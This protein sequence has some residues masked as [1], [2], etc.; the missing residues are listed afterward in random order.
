MLRRAWKPVAATVV[1]GAPAYFYYRS[2]HSGPQTFEFPIR[3]RGASG[4]SEMVNRTFSLV[5]LKELEAR[6]RQHAVSEAQDR[7]DGISWRH[8]TAALASNDPIEDANAHQIIER[9]ASDPSA[10]GDYLFF[11]VMD[12]H[13]GY[14]TS[15][16]LS[17]ILIKGVALELSALLADP[18]SAPQNGMLQRIKSLLW[19]TSSVTATPDADPARVSLAIQDA[20][21][22]LDKELIEA[23]LRI[24]ANNLEKAAWKSKTIPDLSQHPLALTAMLPAISGSCALMAV[25]DTAHRDLYVAC[26]GDSRAVA[27]V[28]EPSTDGKGHWRIEVLSEDQ[29]G[30]NPSELARVRSEHPREEEDYVIREGRILGGLEPS[31][32]FG[33]ARYKWPRPV[34]EALNEAFMVGNNRP[35]RAPPSLFKTPP[36]VI[37]RPVVTHRKMSLAANGSKPAQNAR[38]FLVLATD[39][40][41][42]QLSNDEVVSL[43]GGH[44]AGLKGTIPKSELPTLVPT[45]SG[46]Q[47]VE[48]KNKKAK[49]QEGSWAFNDDNLSAHLI[50]NAFG[51]GDVLALRKLL[52]IPA[53]HSRRY[54]DDVTVTVVCWEDGKEEQAK[55]VTEKLKSKL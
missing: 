43:V 41:W 16:L 14:E 39:G 11:A 7:P 42:D 13:G 18:K 1:I 32:A 33:D 23:P 26:T 36:Y 40:L 31:R 52:S 5:P 47:G 34:Q 45:S 17:R 19:S 2:Y 44:L 53:P 9:D 8:T 25:F 38:R 50:R 4:K 29:T 49:A 55:I 21:T 22:K 20:F 35:M 3:V 46:S 15:Q 54:R 12:G 27:G 30:R 10:P 28:W 37:A 6:I 48:G 51:G 24:L